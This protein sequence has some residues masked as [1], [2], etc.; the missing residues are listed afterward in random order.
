MTRRAKTRNGPHCTQESRKNPGLHSIAKRRKLVH[1]V[2]P[3]RDDEEAQNICNGIV[4]GFEQGPTQY[5]VAA[6]TLRT[7]GTTLPHVYVLHDCSWTNGTCRC[8]IFAGFVRRPNRS[9]IWSTNASAW[10][11][12]NLVQYL[13]SQPRLLEF[14][15][16]GGS[17]WGRDIRK[18]V[19]GQFQGPGHKP[20]QVLKILHPK[21][22][23][24]VACD[25]AHGGQTS[26]RDADKV[27]ARKGT[28]CRKRAKGVSEELIYDWLRGNPVS[29]LSNIVRTP[30]WLADPVFWFIR[31][32]DKRRQ[33]AIQVFNDEMCSYSTVDFIEMYKN[34]QPLF[35]APHGDLATFYMDVPASFDAMTEL[36]NFQ[37]HG[38]YEE[39]SAFVNNLYSLVE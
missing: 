6:V 39:V 20:G 10:D 27:C 1:D 34:T 4:R 19:L 11:L 38:K 8:V 29:P 9:S 21:L 26:G 13:N 28:K 12:Y 37:F 2:F 5:G 7:R 16:V 25:D 33:Q 22:P 32:D 31:L 23:H 14:V 18:E 3:A 30:K 24:S 15:K 36:L 17:D 35:D